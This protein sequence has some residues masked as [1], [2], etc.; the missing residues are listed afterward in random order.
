MAAGR[1]C[2]FLKKLNLLLP[3]GAGGEVYVDSS[4]PGGGRGCENYVDCL[5]IRVEEGYADEDD[6]LEDK[7][8]ER[9]CSL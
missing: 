5:D 3:A 4:A 2:L 6:Q 1:G 8:T 9:C 7:N